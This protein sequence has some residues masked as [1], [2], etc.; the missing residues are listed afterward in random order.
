MNPLTQAILDQL[1]HGTT[2]TDTTTNATTSNNKPDERTK[3]VMKSLVTHLHGFIEE[4]QPTHEEWKLGIDFLTKTGQMCTPERQEFI[5]LSDVLGVSILVDSLNY[6]HDCDEGE[7]NNNTETTTTAT[8]TESTILGPFYRE[9]APELPNGSTITTPEQMAKGTPL[10]VDCRVVD[11]SFDGDEN[12]PVTNA[13]VNVWQASADGLYDVQKSEN[14]TT[15][16]LRAIFHP[17]DEDGRFC[18]H[19]V[20]PSSYP[21]PH[22][23]PVGELLDA[24]GRHPYRP[25]HIHFQIV[26]PGFESLT[27]HLF[28]EGDPYLTSDAV[29]AVKDSLIIGLAEKDNKNSNQQKEYE[30]KYTFRLKRKR[31]RGLNDMH[32]VDTS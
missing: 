31:R 21:I 27:T 22:D 19:T 18:F 28:I 10:T 4:T 26:A 16:D 25:A 7:V 5:L 15:T 24:M 9:Y 29:H 14:H 30:L 32:L 13:T 3:I 8:T 12:V 1:D 11:G 23:G 20:Q 2:T 6:H 17:N